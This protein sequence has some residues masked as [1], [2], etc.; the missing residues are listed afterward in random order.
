MSGVSGV[1]GVSGMSGVL[2]LAATSLGG[3]LR[4]PSA[5]V[6]LLEPLT[7]LRFSLS[8]SSSSSIVH[9]RVR[10]RAACNM[11]VGGEKM[12]QMSDKDIGQD[13]V[14]CFH[15]TGLLNIKCL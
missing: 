15:V 9:W 14:T 1:S 2:S 12:K 4:S 5:S 6:A 11:E 3:G 13:C 8:T 7:R 10:L